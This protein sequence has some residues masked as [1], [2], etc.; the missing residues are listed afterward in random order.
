MIINNYQESRS[1]SQLFATNARLFSEF[2]GASKTGIYSPS[3]AAGAQE[4]DCTTPPQKDPPITCSST[5]RPG[6][7]QASAAARDVG[8]IRHSCNSKSNQEVRAPIDYQGSSRASCRKSHRFSIFCKGSMIRLARELPSK[9]SRPI[10]SLWRAR[11]TF[12]LC[13]VSNTAVRPSL[14]R[15]DKQPECGRNRSRPGRSRIGSNLS[16][17]SVCRCLPSNRG[18]CHHN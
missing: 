14:Q 13:I 15:V 8:W 3:P 6:V 18:N 2:F 16:C 5:F 10:G 7:A 11:L 1:S 17:E 9:R 4:R 12:P